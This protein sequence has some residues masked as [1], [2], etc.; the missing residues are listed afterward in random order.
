MVAVLAE[1]NT[2]PGAK[3][4]PAICDRDLHRGAQERGLDVGRHVIGT[5]EGVLVV[6]SIFRH[7]LVKLTFEINPH[8]GVS[9]FVDRKAGGSMLNENMKHA[10]LYLPQLRKLVQYFRGD[11]VKAPGV[12]FEQYFPLIKCHWLILI[13]FLPFKCANQKAIFLYPSS[14]SI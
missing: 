8:G 7:H 12:W 2:L 11:E 3:V 6:G 1:I 10:G 14:F 9:I 4:K 5:F 13:A